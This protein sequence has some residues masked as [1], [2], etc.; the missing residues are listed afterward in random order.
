MWCVTRVSLVPY[1]TEFEVNLNENR[2]AACVNPTVTGSANRHLITCDDPT[3]V[4]IVTIE[5]P[6]YMKF[7]SKSNELCLQE[8]NRIRLTLD[9]ETPSS[10]DFVLRTLRCIYNNDRA[11]Q[12]T[13]KI[14]KFCVC[15]V[16]QLI[17][18]GL[19][20]TTLLPHTK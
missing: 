13:V 3:T 10:W 14:C 7:I 17:K 8:D 9:D 18:Y 11:L 5:E 12:V 19:I 4:T 6:E 20:I 1:P 16:K 2:A 15:L